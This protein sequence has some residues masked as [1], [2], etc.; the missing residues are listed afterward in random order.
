MTSTGNGID[1][2]RFLKIG[3][4]TSGLAVGGCSRAEIEA[5]EPAPAEMRFRALGATGLKV[6]EISFG[7]Y[8]F[9]NPAL[10]TAAL[11]RGITT[12]CTSANYQNG[13]AETS[14]GKA[15]GNLGGRRDELVVFTGDMF[16]A[17]ATT[18]DV[19]DAI[20]ASLRRLQTDRVEIYRITNV[21]SL[22]ELRIDAL[23]EAFA[24]AKKAGKVLHLGLSGHHGGMQEILSA[25]VDDGRY[26]VLFTKYDFASYPDQDRILQAAATKGIGTM[27]F[28]TNAGNRKNE[29]RDLEAGGLSFRQATIKW[30]LSHPYV[31]SVCVAITNFD[32]IHEYA[33]AVGKVLN[34]AEVAMLRRYA[35]EMYDRYCRFCGECEGRCPHGVAIADV[36]RYAMYFKYYGRE[37]DSM[38]LYEA[39][40]GGRTAGACAGCEG[41]CDAGCPFHRAVRH[42]LVDAHRLLSFTR[43]EA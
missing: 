42:E 33:Q 10:L 38:R 35:D 8:G 2:R 6:S 7:S 19:L 16:K 37:K 11:D 1:R 22:D 5:A 3:A 21:T 14:I 29:I 15:I 18:R 31:A 24:V 39:L 41:H 17:N 30:A 9:D 32:E 4:M 36:N 27:V 26:E 25:A 20:D 23:Y 12:I 43:G 40:G 34:E 13:R 28:K